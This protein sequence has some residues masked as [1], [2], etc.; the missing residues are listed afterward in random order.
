M[1]VTDYTNVPSWLDPATLYG[2][3]EAGG[4]YSPPLMG[5]S[6]ATSVETPLKPPP[7]TARQ[8]AKMNPVQKKPAQP[9]RIT[10]PIVYEDLKGNVVEVVGPNTIPDGP[11]FYGN[12]KKDEHEPWTPSIGNATDV[13]TP[14]ATPQQLVQSATA[15]NTPINSRATTYANKVEPGPA[16]STVQQ[17]SPAPAAVNVPVANPAPA[18]P[19][20]ANSEKPTPSATVDD[21]NPTVTTAATAP[22]QASLGD[23]YRQL[24][25][26]T[27]NRY[28]ELSPDLD[29]AKTTLEAAQKQQLASYDKVP[30]RPLGF[31]EQL[32]KTINP[33]KPPTAAEIQRRLKRERG[34]KAIAA[35]GDGISAIANLVGTSQGALN[36]YDGKSTMSQR[37]ADMYEALRQ[38][39][40]LNDEKYYSTYLSALGADDAN[41][42][43]IRNNEA[44]KEALNVQNAQASYASLL[45]MLDKLRDKADKYDKLAADQDKADRD[46]QL[47]VDTLQQRA[48]DNEANRDLRKAIADNRNHTSIVVAGMR[49]GG[50]HGGGRSGSGSGSKSMMPVR[51]FGGTGK[52]LIDSGITVTK[53]KWNNNQWFDSLY[54]YIVTQTGLTGHAAKVLGGARRASTAT[55]RMKI[56]HVLHSDYNPMDQQRILDAIS[57]YNED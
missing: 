43:A 56:A 41:A 24:S 28:D 25:A 11:N 47:R 37:Y 51:V 32:M 3:E 38:E 36:A 10:Q 33:Y 27:L 46:Y 55:K 14:K 12:L 21:T 29:A 39:R 50:S 19:Q 16:A 18:A 4:G 31:Y 52:D 35:I 23:Y 6:N 17:A 54:D 53:S 22:K 34:Q 40:K 7:A 1:P 42:A 8:K 49:G 5:S 20:P 48:A 26:A 30:F 44:T 2:T 13:E 45:S 57:L 9:A 15:P